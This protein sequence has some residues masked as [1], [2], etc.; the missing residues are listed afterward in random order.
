MANSGFFNSI[1]P[2]TAK[3]MH[4]PSMTAGEL[5]GMLAGA[6]EGRMPEATTQITSAPIFGRS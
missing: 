3:D 2:L 5:C 4:E 6:N 1:A